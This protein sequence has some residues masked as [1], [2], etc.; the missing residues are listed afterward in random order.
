MV[1]SKLKASEC[2]RIISRSFDWAVGL[3]RVFLRLSWLSI[4]C[5]FVCLF[6]R[7]LTGVVSGVEAVAGAR[8]CLVFNEGTWRN[9]TGSTDGF[10]SRLYSSR[11]CCVC[12]GKPVR[13]VVNK[14]PCG[15][16]FT[17]PTILSPSKR[18]VEF[19]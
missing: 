12:T 11:K 19:E 2:L 4:S 9:E 1:P 6:R 18:I 8:C 10:V 16:I 5:S 13:T 15:V 3:N 7:L 14:L 17:L